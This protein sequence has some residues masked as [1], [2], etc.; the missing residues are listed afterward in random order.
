[1]FTSIR[2]FVRPCNIISLNARFA[3]AVKSTAFTFQRYTG[4]CGSHSNALPSLLPLSIS[5]LLFTVLRQIWKIWHL[6][7]SA[8]KHPHRRC[9][10]YSRTHVMH[11]ATGLRFRYRTTAVIKHVATPWATSTNAKFPPLNPLVSIK[12]TGPRMGGRKT[13]L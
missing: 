10:T 7:P 5:T 8:A 12:Q 2:R 6:D 1:M 3:T 9:N 4:S 13:A 11:V